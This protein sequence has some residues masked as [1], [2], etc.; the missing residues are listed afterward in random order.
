MN[1]SDV[2]FL[3]V[4]RLVDDDEE[5]LA[6]FRFLL[7]G[8]GWFVRTYSSAES[9][10]ERDNFNVPGCAIVDIRMNGMSGLEL[11]DVLNRRGIR[12]PLIFLSGHGT[13]ENVV[14]S[15]ESGAVTFLSKPVSLDKLR[16][17][18]ARA[19]ESAKA[20]SDSEELLRS[21]QSLTSKEKEVARLI[22]EGLLNKQIADRLSIAER[23]VQAHRSKVYQKLAAKNGIDVY[24]ALQQL[25]AA[26]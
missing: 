16:V 6:S 7:E 20:I 3:A 26:P 5:L 18:V 8:E 12:L 19:M 17:A 23:T 21:W 10:L 2:K 15:L 9:F 22:S 11:Q 25:G 13:V 1:P 14:E 4:I 24:K